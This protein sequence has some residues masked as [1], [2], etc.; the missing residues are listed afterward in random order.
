MKTIH[1]MFDKNKEIL[2]HFLQPLIGFIA[3][4][5]QNIISLSIDFNADIDIPISCTFAAKTDDQML[6]FDVCDGSDNIVLDKHIDYLQSNKIV[7]FKRAYDSSL[8]QKYNFINPLGLNYFGEYPDPVQR[9][10][11]HYLFK[12]RKLYEWFK[13][14]CGSSDLDKHW[15]MRH[16]V[17]AFHHK[18]TVL[19][20]TR[21]WDYSGVSCRVE[22]I[23]ET[24]IEAVKAIRKNFNQYAIAGFCDSPLARK[25]CPE[26]ILPDTMTKRRHF[27][28]LMNHA[29]ICI[30][31]TGLH[32]ST[33]WRF[34]EFIA[35]G[36]AIISEP[37]LFATPGNLK[38]GKNYLSF[39]S[40]DQ[41]I[42]SAD[43][44]LSHP[45]SIRNME[46]ENL[47]YYYHFL[48]PDVMIFN[49]IKPFI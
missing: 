19:L 22:E 13:F 41:L 39:D 35:A 31:T 3:L 21:L 24:R 47:D 49:A 18:E 32:R 36:K 45:Q 16:R 1:L 40:I 37:L 2:S 42:S 33:G 29:S 17:K 46:K 10:Y 38:E 5:R 15:S 8:Y 44:L 27:I 6:F 48:R 26:L 9:F 30:A 4:N 12:N 34:A 14:F 25:R 11:F 20:S 43:Y 28:E 7:L 23:N